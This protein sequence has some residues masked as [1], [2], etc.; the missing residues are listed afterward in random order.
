MRS[1]QAV[2][3]LPNVAAVQ[4]KS[5]FSTRVYVRRAPAEGDR[6]RRA[7]LRAAERRRDHRQVRLGTAAGTVLTDTQN[8]T[9]GKFSGGAGAP[10]RVI[11]ADGKVQTLRVSGHGRYLGGGQI[12]AEGGFAVF[13][14]TPKTVTAL[15]GTAGYTMLAMRL[16]DSSRPAAERTAAAVGAQLRPVNGFT[17]FA[18]YPE[19]RTPATIRARSCSSRSRRS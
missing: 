11:A 8:A 15:T 4:P 12:V 3:R 18:D 9:K 17:G 2:G 16:N 10:V 19:I 1:S 6:H 14:A 7:R 5:V 13:Y